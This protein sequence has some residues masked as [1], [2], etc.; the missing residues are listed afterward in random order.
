MMIQMNETLALMGIFYLEFVEFTYAVKTWN[1]YKDI[2][3]GITYERRLD[4]PCEHAHAVAMDVKVRA[5]PFPLEYAYITREYMKDYKEAFP[6]SSWWERFSSL[7]MGCSP[8]TCEAN[9]S[10]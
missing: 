6:Y 7:W 5:L 1:M 2:R 9:Q 8:R 3:D 10:V 4:N